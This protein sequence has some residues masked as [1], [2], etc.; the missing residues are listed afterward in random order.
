MWQK[1]ST[2]FV[3]GL[4]TLLPLLV[5]IWL[6]WFMYTFLDGILG[7][8]IAMFIGHP[9]PLVGFVLIMLLILLTGYFTTYIVGARLSNLGKNCFTAY[10]SSRAFTPPPSR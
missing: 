5:T 7:N 1:L 9:V 6:L 4:I 8:I 2:S 10:R 3:R